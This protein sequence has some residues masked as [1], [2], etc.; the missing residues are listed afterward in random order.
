MNGSQPFVYITTCGCVFSHAGY[1][2][3]AGSTSTSSGSSSPKEKETEEPQTKDSDQLDLCP[4]CATKYSKPND[5]LFLNPSPE[6]EERMHERME[7]LRLLEP[8]KKSKSKKRKNNPTTGG[9]DEVLEPPTKKVVP[10]TNPSIAA[11]SRAVVSSLAMEE[12]KRKANMSEAVKSLYGDGKAKREE[13]FMTRGT[14]TR[15]SYLVSL[16]GFGFFVDSFFL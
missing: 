4:Q 15:V 10:S 16:M 2:T 3:L 8:T 5:V 6:E 7:K 9:E 12:A 11:A 14:F 13:T 1:K